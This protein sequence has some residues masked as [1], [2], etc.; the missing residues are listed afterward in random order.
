MSAEEIVRASQHG[1]VVIL[2]SHAASTSIAYIL[3]RRADTGKFNL[4]SKPLNGVD[5]HL[6][7]RHIEQLERANN[8]VRGDVDR[9]LGVDT[10]EGDKEVRPDSAAHRFAH[11][12]DDVFDLPDNNRAVRVRHK[13]A[14]VFKIVLKSLWAEVVK[15]ILDYLNIEVSFSERFLTE[16]ANKFSSH[17]QEETGHDYGGALVVTSLFFPFTPPGTT[18]LA[19][20]A[21]Q[22]LLFRLIPR[23]CLRSMLHESHTTQFVGRTP[24]HW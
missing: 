12:M 6:L 9:S 13:T 8:E 18:S 4:T 11:G 1:P 22:T 23:R 2:F 20:N 7:R 19:A 21:A 3:F 10:S 15:P 14:D 16:L 17:R 24:K 5:V